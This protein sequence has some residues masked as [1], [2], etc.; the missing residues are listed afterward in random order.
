MHPYVISLKNLFEQNA[1][2]SKAAPM[3]KYMR[4]QFEYLGIKSPQVS[5]L[6][7]GHIS[8]Y[9]LPAFDELDEPSLPTQLAAQPFHLGVIE[10]LE[11]AWIRLGRVPVTLQD[12][13]HDPA[14]VAPLLTVPLRLLYFGIDAGRATGA[15]I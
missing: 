7:R 12:G 15:A 3:K 2:P 1:D 8:E 13:Q 6:L 4:D 14:D 10:A 11:E 5:Q 9:E